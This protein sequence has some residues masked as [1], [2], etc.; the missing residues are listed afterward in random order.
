MAKNDCGLD[1]AD[2]NVIDL[3]PMSDEGGVGNMQDEDPAPLSYLPMQLPPIISNDSVRPDDHIPY[4]GRA[5]K[6]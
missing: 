3:G 2:E 4:G 1:N 5:N 6:G